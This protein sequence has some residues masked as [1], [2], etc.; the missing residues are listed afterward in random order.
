MSDRNG[1]R[2]TVQVP[3]PLL[4]DIDE[5]AEEQARTRSE[6]VRDCM[7]R[8]RDVNDG[9]LAAL[10]EPEKNL[11]TCVDRLIDEVH[12]LGQSLDDIQDELE[13]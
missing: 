13:E 6:V 3:E 8:Y 2:M 5:L 11:G 4:D 12:W 10:T 1:Q 9:N 7:R